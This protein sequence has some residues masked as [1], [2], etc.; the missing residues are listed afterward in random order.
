MA[1]QRGNKKLSENSAETHNQ[2]DLDAI[3]AFC[4]GVEFEEIEFDSWCNHNNNLD[5][6]FHLSIDPQE[7]TQGCQKTIELSRTIVCQTENGTSSRR[8][9]SKHQIE[10]EAGIRN[11]HRITLEG[12]G[13]RDMDQCGHLHVIV[14]FT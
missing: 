10:I 6:E 1:S 7:A 14:R 3:E 11:G 8:E 12:C 13:D 5:L 2:E 4:S 9:K